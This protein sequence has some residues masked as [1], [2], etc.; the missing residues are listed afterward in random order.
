MLVRSAGCGGIRRE[1]RNP[2]LRSSGAGI[3]A[4]A[5]AGRLINV[6]WLNRQE[7]ISL[8]D[9]SIPA[10]S[11]DRVHFE[12]ALERGETMTAEFGHERRNFCRMYTSIKVLFGK[13]A[14][15]FTGIVDSIGF[16]GARIR[17]PRTFPKDSTFILEIPIPDHSDLFEAQAKVAW[18]QERD[19]M[20]V[21][22]LNLDQKEILLL[23]KL[24]TPAATGLN[25]A[26]PWD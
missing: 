4:G 22:F 20:G 9:F 7:E 19:S 14:A 18:V 8:N 5:R 15:S 6:L 26:D 21:Q 16:G 24:L 17:S 25:H 10:D 12:I 3:R 2:L 23:E 13:Q 1:S 11:I